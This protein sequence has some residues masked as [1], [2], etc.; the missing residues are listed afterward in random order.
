MLMLES[1]DVNADVDLIKM[2]VLMYKFMMMMFR[3]DGSWT[4]F[5]I[6]T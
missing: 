6:P 2:L 5:E 4:L 1:I 3:S